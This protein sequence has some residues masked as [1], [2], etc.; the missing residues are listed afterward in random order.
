MDLERVMMVEDEQDIQLIARLALERVGKLNVLVCSS[1]AEA[2][3]QGP[4]FAPQMIM[5]DVMMPGM[6]GPTTLER[7][8]EIPQ[9]VD[10][11][12]VFMTAKVQRQDEERYRALGA[13]GVIAKP[14]DPMSLAQT[15]KTIWATESCTTV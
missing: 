2:L 5:L 1:G 14:F 6:D 7:L 10:V 9:L 11:P 12:V 4:D 15:L 13:I 3:E 8:R